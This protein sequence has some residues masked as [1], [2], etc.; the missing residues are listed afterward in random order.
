MKIMPNRIVRYF[1]YFGC[2]LSRGGVTRFSVFK[3]ALN[4]FYSDYIGPEYY[5]KK[6]L[7]YAKTY[8]LN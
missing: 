1:I 3:A 8:G 4:H 7:F 2:S 6:P 5:L